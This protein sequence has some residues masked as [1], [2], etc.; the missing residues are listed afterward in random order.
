MAVF[1]DSG[2]FSF[3]EFEDS[4]GKKRLTPIHYRDL[5]DKKGDMYDKKV[6][7]SDVVINGVPLEQTLQYE[8]EIPRGST[9]EEK[10][11]VIIVNERKCEE[12]FPSE[13]EKD[14]KYEK[15]WLTRIEKLSLN[16]ISLP[17]AKRKGDKQGNYPVKPKSK[18]EVRDE[19]LFASSD[20]FQGIIAENSTEEIED[21]VT[22][23]PQKVNG[24]T[25]YK[26]YCP[27]NHW[28]NPVVQ[29][30]KIWREMDK[31][32]TGVERSYHY[33]EPGKINKDGIKGPAIYFYNENSDD[34]NFNF[35]PNTDMIISPSE[36]A[37][38]PLPTFG[39]AM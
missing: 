37:T 23:I 27:P 14:S 10:S 24:V 28:I 9:T 29:W 18:K 19:K 7:W 16:P 38:S 22:Y 1:Y 17:E 13:T 34:I 2:K 20:H 31:I 15:K 25:Q 36:K 30:D 12:N 4:S 33:V 6:S 5:G 32:Q 39:I 21:Y 3:I 35:N 11:S 26:K 8:N